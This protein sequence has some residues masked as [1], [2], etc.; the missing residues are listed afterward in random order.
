MPSRK[1][2]SEDIDDMYLGRA[3]RMFSRINDKP[4]VCIDTLAMKSYVCFKIH[5]LQ[6]NEGVVEGICDWQDPA[7]NRLNE[8]TEGIAIGCDLLDVGDVWWFDMY[9]QWYY[10]FD[11]KLASHSLTG[12]HSWVSGFVKRTE[13][14]RT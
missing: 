5:D 4:C 1:M 14:N 3:A 10:V 11:Q 6:V 12:D 9:F 7:E 2:N 13:R 8:M